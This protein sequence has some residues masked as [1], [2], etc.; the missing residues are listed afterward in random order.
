MNNE[1]YEFGF[2]DEL[3]KLAETDNQRLRREINSMRAGTAGG[4]LGLT[5]P[6]LAAPWLRRMAYKVEHLPTKFTGNINDYIDQLSPVGSFAKSKL[7][8]SK[9]LRDFAKGPRGTVAIPVAL[10][11]AIG[12]A[13]LYNAI[14]KRM[15][16]GN[17]D[18]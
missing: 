15:N 1:A 4:I 9:F 12:S 14:A 16:K 13:A 7:Q 5:A 11:T 10:G 17:K 3:Q 18:D 8:V 2:N 6:T